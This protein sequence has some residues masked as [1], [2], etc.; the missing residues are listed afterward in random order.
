MVV[1]RLAESPKTASPLTASQ[2]GSKGFEAK[3]RRTS[4]FFSEALER[5]EPPGG[6]AGGAPAAGLLRRWQCAPGPPGQGS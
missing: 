4:V 6:D 2:E 5:C 1:V 3:R